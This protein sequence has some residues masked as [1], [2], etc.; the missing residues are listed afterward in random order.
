VRRIAI[1]GGGPAGA[2]C[3]RVLAEGGCAVTL[4][5]PR[6]RFEKPCGGG[7]PA[8]GLAEFPF[9]QDPRLPSRRI[10]RLAVVSPSG[11]EAGL[12]LRE[13]LE[14]FARAD[15]HLL[16]LDRAVE[17]GAEVRETRVIRLE[18]RASWLLET[19]S[20]SGE[21]REEGPF[22]FLVAADGASGS[23]HRRLV[24]T[25]PAP[26]L[27]QGI[28][29]YLA[30]PPD[31]EITLKFF[32][33]MH[34][35]LWVFPRPDHASAGIC[36]TLGEIPAAALRERM[37]RFLA[38]R[39]GADRVASAARYAALIPGAPRDPSAARLTGPGW[40]VAGDAGRAVD[41]LT[42]EGI[43]YA[44]LSGDRL[45]RAL[46]AGRVEDYATSWRREPGREFAWA[47]RHSAGFFRPRFI[48][49]LVALAGRSERVAAVLGD[50]ISGRQ[51]YRTLK[52]RLVLNAP[53]IAW[54]AARRRP[55][56]RTPGS[57]TPVRGS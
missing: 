10:R 50:L 30:G 40:A 39:Y 47:A 2:Q 7:V 9:L 51:P 34:G 38:G 27:T 54:Q 22:D 53:A 15:L 33:G 46:V 44:I 29:C 36:A 42:S 1:V 14:V 6:R 18:R 28:G 5:E 23:A 16:M 56:G 32:A 35:Y 31:E 20:A 49:H 25:P 55:S 45:A 48:E 24:G 57:L 11:R 21:V 41:P 12:D 17:A 43:Y 3:A 37:D 19:A 8:R 4:F 13:P 52:R 26:D